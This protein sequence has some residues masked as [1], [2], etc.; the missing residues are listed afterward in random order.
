M[1]ERTTVWVGKWWVA[2]KKNWVKYEGTVFQTGSEQEARPHC[3]AEHEERQETTRIKVQH[4]KFWDS[5]SYHLRLWNK[6]T[7]HTTQ[8]CAF[9]CV[10]HN[11]NVDISEDVINFRRNWNVSVTKVSK[12]STV[13]QV[14]KNESQ[15]R[16]YMCKMLY[17]QHHVL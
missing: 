10:L 13:S 16:L 5:G 6:G 11:A 15:T 2:T 12:P 17:D 4:Q 8:I 9:Y 7:F 14:K 1:V 3:K